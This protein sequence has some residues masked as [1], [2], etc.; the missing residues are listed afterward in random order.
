M[1]NVVI[2]DEHLI[3]IAD[4]IREKNGT[5]ETYK[6]SEMATAISAI[7]TGGGGNWD[8]S[9]LHSVVISGSN[10]S[11][12]LSGEELIVGISARGYP[13]NYSSQNIVLIGFNGDTVP[14]LEGKVFSPCVR[15]EASGSNYG[16]DIDYEGEELTISTSLKASGTVYYNQLLNYVLR[17]VHIYYYLPKEEA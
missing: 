16:T 13:E 17:G 7:E 2:N 15:Y 9:Q 4:A 11:S 6:P 5:E 12:Y 10:L 1:A 14:A 3:S 8:Y